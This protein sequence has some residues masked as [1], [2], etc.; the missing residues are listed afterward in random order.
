MLWKLKEGGGGRKCG[1]GSGGESSIGRVGKCGRP[2]AV[3]NMA[4]AQ[5]LL[6][7]LYP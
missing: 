3:A 4:E 7:V 1:E 6:A 5:S 2:E